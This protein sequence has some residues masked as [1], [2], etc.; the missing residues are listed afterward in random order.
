MY[1]LPN[2]KI[3][4]GLNVVAKR[5]DGYHDLQTVFYPIPLT[6]S[7]ELK[8]GSRWDEAC[9]LVVS[10]LKVEG[11]KED[12]LVY[13]VF[14][15]LQKEFQLPPTIIFLSKHIPTGAGLGG[16]SSDAAFTMTMAN[17]KFRLGLSEKDMEA[18]LSAF[19]SDCPFF[20]RNRPVYAEGTGNIFSQIPIDLKGWFLLLV[21][22]PISV[23]TKQAYDSIRPAMPAISLKERLT[24]TPVPAWRDVIQNDFEPA[25]FT[26]Y[27]QIAAIKATLYDMG[28]AYASMSGSGSAIYGLFPFPVKNAKT[29]FPESFTF[30]CQL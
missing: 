20:V 28:A 9:T 16:G 2:A 1:T 7:L 26:A 13:K 19:G 18:R 23:S 25:I 5:N 11:A 24:T 3:N 15:S 6:D 22:P 29:I 12:N 10:G 4:I 27:P 17:E 21:K 8:D 14:T 30:A